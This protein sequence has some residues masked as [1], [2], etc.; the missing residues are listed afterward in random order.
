MFGI[1]YYHLMRL[2]IITRLCNDADLKVSRGLQSIQVRENISQKGPRFV[3][4]TISV[5][6]EN[7]PNEE[8]L[9]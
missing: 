9:K 6:L 5:V 8:K 7:L 1:A 4:L 3:G 2:Y